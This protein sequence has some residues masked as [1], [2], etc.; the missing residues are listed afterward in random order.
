MRPLG[1]SLEEDIYTCVLQQANFS[2]ELRK[3]LF[4]Q[5]LQLTPNKGLPLWGKVQAILEKL[6]LPV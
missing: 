2:P 5:R 3:G 4:Y 1:A 6:C